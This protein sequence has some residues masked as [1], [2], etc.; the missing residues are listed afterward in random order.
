M[1]IYRAEDVD[2]ALGTFRVLSRR[3]DW[4]CISQD[5]TFQSFQVLEDEVSDHKFIVANIAFPVAATGE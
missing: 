1:K 2:P 3:T 4:I 5:W